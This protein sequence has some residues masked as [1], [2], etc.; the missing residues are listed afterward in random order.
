MKLKKLE[1]YGFK[2]FAQR[3]EI[4]FNEG[5]T[6]I[7]GPNGSGKSNIGDAVRWVL[8]EQS[9]RSLRGAKME[10]IIF[11]GT[12]KRKAM[13]YCEVSLVFD[14]EDKSLPIDFTEV[15][16][17]RRVFR[18]GDSEYY[19]NQSLC[20]LKDVIALFRDTGIGKEGYSIIGQGRIDDILS[21]KSEDRRLIFEEAAGIVKFKSRKEEAQHKLSRTMDNLSRV[22]DITKELET[23][24]EPLGKQADIAREY[25]YLSSELKTLDLNIYLIRH[26]KIK[27]RIEELDQTL[28]NLQ[29][30]LNHADIETEKK[31][32]ERS[33]MEKAISEIEL[34]LATLRQG[35]TAVNSEYHDEKSRLQRYI[36]EKQNRQEHLVRLQTELANDKEKL[37]NL[38]AMRNESQDGMEKQDVL[39]KAQQEALGEKEEALKEAVQLAMNTEETLEAHKAAV[40]EA[41]NHVSNL[42]ATTER[43]QAI[44][45]QMEIRLV[46]VE[47]SRQELLESIAELETTYQTAEAEKASVS[48][49][50]ENLKNSAA[51][52]DVK[53]QET[54]H[55]ANQMND[56]IQHAIQEGRA[57]ESRLKTLEEMAKGYEGYYHSVRHALTYAK[58]TSQ[59]GVR[60]VVAMLLEVPKPYETAID[61]VLGATLQHIVTEDEQS[62]K[63]IIAYLRENKLGRATFLPMTTIRSKTLSNEE[64]RVLSMKGCIGVA[65]E[66]V[67]YASEYKAI[68]ESLLGRTIIAE[69]LD[70]GI[71]IMR[72]GRHAFRLVTLDG[73]VMHSGGSMTGGSVQQRA[74]NFLSREREIKELRN[75]LAD[76][77]KQI[78]DLGKTKAMLDDE[79]VKLRQQYQEGLSRMHQEEIAVAREQERVTAIAAQLDD[80]K[81]RL[82]TTEQAYEQLMEGIASIDD[83]LEKINSQ[84]GLSENDIHA[85]QAQT[86]A[87]RLTCQDARDKQEILRTSLTEDMLA[88]SKL[89]H[90]T[91]TLRKDKERVQ[92]EIDALNVQIQQTNLTFEAIFLENE[93]SENLLESSKERVALLD[94]K[95]QQAVEMVESAEKA[96][97]QK[98][99]Q[100]NDIH[101]QIEIIHQS[102]AHDSDK[103]HQTELQKARQEG[104]L[105][106]MQERIWNTYELTYEGAETFRQK[107]KF[108]LT[109]G[110]KR[111]NELRQSIRLLG[112]V[113]VGAI[114]EFADTK[115]RYDELTTQRDDL[116]TAKEDLETLIV[117]L[118]TQMEKQF[119]S[120]FALMQTYFKETFVRLFGGGQAELK[121][122]DPNDALN[123]GIEI[124]AQPPGKKLQ[125]LSLL[126]GGERALCAIAILFAMLKLKATPFCILDEIEA[127]L[128]EANIGYFADYLVEYGEKT[129]FVVVTHRKGTM[130]HCDALYG[131]AMEEQGVSKM[132]SVNLMDYE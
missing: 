115:A 70:A 59:T 128:D 69:N 1:I 55:Q 65:S 119:T 35:Q 103:R 52:I 25:L 51:A 13:T 98:Q 99:D 64:R 96:R 45:K 97:Q 124:V 62:A 76:G 94:S 118:E 47:K 34:S 49:L 71:A 33:A 21:Q 10:D 61:M 3:T 102:V 121:L 87:L 107:D 7:V 92:H 130:E 9:A 14:N 8:G 82:D 41:M 84:S 39:L 11:G 77:E 123:C 91:N 16:I 116:L 90:E 104:D 73:D 53:V 125:L 48:M 57:M 72:A 22:E 17:T 5:I 117:Q 114:D 32:Q 112:T 66:L 131:V 74:S 105:M 44:K 58:K 18:S 86:E 95:S 80:V 36:L 83:D 78:I 60:N 100:L 132:V 120:Q 46:E 68:V 85:M 88:F 127:A 40:I 30:V 109:N 31:N 6:G 56:K 129:Q 29:A 122:T 43:Q 111:A 28:A 63:E 126:S 93:K 50:F 106:A 23:R 19:I 101:K 42:K 75:T 27:A 15:M 54:T 113:N 37:D 4:V 12:Q 79:C 26:D 2:S 81:M 110:E 24:L 108:E 20:R 67:T 38:Y 89:E